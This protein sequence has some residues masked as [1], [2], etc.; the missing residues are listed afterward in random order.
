MVSPQVMAQ[1][2]FP[3]LNH[4]LEPLVRAGFKLVWH[5][6][7][8]MNDMLGPLIDVGIAGF[9]GFQEE[10]GTRIVDVARLR[11][12]SGDPLI[13]WGSVS[14]VDVVRNGTYADIRREVKRVLEQWPH[15]GL[16]LGTASAMMEDV[17]HDNITELYRLFR[18]L[19]TN[20][21]AARRR[22]VLPS[23]GSA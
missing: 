17:P 7:G 10:C 2:Y 12:R 19:G 21:G 4:A 18:T 16:C 20:Q 6:D 8:S 9:Q 15:P 14:A 11:T 23:P 5:S 22:E 3:H 1:R 13:L